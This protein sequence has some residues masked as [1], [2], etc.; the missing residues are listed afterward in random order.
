[1]A[2]KSPL[3][4]DNSLLHSFIGNVECVSRFKYFEFND[5]LKE[6]LQFFKIS[7]NLVFFPHWPGNL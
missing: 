7:V 6:K 4:F 5:F 3:G 2:K 1:M